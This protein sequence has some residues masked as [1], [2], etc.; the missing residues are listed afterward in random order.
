MQSEYTKFYNTQVWKDAHTFTLHIY[1][2]TK[3]FP[4]T[5]LFGLTSQIRRSSS[6]IG[7]NIAE[8]YQ[9]K[10]SKMKINYLFIAKTTC[11][12]T[13]NHLLL[14]KDLGYISESDFNHLMK[15]TELILRQIGGWIKKM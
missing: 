15:Q 1:K 12:E 8:G 5:E 14:A 13:Q 3:K 2:V 7:A 4:K 6:A 11:I 9:Q 10:S